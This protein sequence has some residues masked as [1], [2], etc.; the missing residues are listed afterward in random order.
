MSYDYNHTIYLVYSVLAIIA[1]FAIGYGFKIVYEQEVN[2]PSLLLA[3]TGSTILTLGLIVCVEQ[4]LAKI[5]SKY[6]HSYSQKTK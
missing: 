3:S 2:I 6:K 4:F 5:I 1:S